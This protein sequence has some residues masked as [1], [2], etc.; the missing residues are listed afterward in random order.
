MAASIDPYVQYNIG[1]RIK[2]RKTTDGKKNNGIS[3][4]FETFTL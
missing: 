4:T 1:F 3:I 2:V